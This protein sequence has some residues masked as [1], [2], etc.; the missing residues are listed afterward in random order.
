MFSEE[1]ASVCVESEITIVGC[2]VLHISR[3]QSIIVFS[4]AYSRH[5]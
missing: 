3:R 5:L 1:C 2:S 4:L